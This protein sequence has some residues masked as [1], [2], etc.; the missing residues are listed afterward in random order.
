M[1]V[2]LNSMVIFARVVEERGFS[3]AARRLAVSKSAVSKQIAQLEDRIGARL[4]HRTTRSLRLTDVGVAFYER[5]AR[6]LAEA[7]EAEL[8]VSRMSSVPRGTL[9]VSAPVSFGSRFLAAPLAEFAVR[10]PEVRL[11]MVLSDRVVDLVD[12]GYDLAIR[13]GRL[14]DSSLIARRLCAMPLHIVAAPAYLAA[15]GAPLVPADLAKH[16][17]L[18]YSLS[19]HGDVYFCRDG[20]REVAVKVEGSMRANNG[21][22]LLAAVLR[23]VGLA[24]MPAFLS[25]SELRAGTLEEILRPYRATAGAVSAVYPHN[26]HLSAKVRVFVDFLADHFTSV[27]WGDMQ[28]AA[29]TGA[30]VGAE[31]AR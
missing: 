16:N 12:E 14:A 20:E 23:G 21:D 27:P 29:A 17:C 18:L 22:V 19:T 31:G 24:V 3:A 25:A 9:R 8:A 5:C 7:E 13:I 6:I 10:C 30:A 28:P 4:L 26:R 1:A 15:H 11:E 2:D